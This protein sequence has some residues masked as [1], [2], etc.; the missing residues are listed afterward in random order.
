MGSK[1]PRGRHLLGLVK[2]DDHGVS[3]SSDHGQNDGSKFALEILPIL[4][5]LTLRIDPFS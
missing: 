4:T 1:S 3:S 5:L 2:T